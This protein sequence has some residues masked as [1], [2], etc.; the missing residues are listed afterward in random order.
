MVMNI[1]DV[2]IPTQLP[3]SSLYSP[4]RQ[5][6]VFVSGLH[7]SVEVFTV[8][9]YTRLWYVTDPKVMLYSRVKYR[10]YTILS[11]INSK[12]THLVARLRWRNGQVK[13][14]EKCA[15]QCVVVVP[16]ELYSSTRYNYIYII[17]IARPGRSTVSFQ[18]NGRSKLWTWYWSY[19]IIMD[20]LQCVIK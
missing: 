6:H 14:Q 18:T 7:S 2:V 9:I 15:L 19:T 12:V 1:N 13:M 8:Y 11:C 10:L 20:L 17:H 16:S 4:G 3:S 5:S